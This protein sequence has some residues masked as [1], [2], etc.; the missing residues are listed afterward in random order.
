MYIFEDV[1]DIMLQFESI[2]VGTNSNL[3]NHSAV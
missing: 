3:F 2:E 1:G